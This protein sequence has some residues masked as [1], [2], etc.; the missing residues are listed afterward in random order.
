M[1]RRLV[2]SDL[3]D[4]LHRMSERELHVFCHLVNRKPVSRN[5]QDHVEQLTF[6]QRRFDPYPFILLTWFFPAWLQ[7]RRP[8]S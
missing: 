4:P 3:A 6:G 7:F 1:E 8:S 2:M 5:P